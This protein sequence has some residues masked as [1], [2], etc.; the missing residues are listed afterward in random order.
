VAVYMGGLSILLLR[1]LKTTIENN[2][3]RINY[4]IVASVPA[5]QFVITGAVNQEIP[6][7]A[8]GLRGVSCD[9]W[10]DYCGSTAL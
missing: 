9:F 7:C 10:F 8:F 6:P 5:Q 3:L 1:V 4:S 2:V